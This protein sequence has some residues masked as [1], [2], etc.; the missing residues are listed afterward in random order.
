MALIENGGRGFL[1]GVLAGAGLVVDGRA[2]L[3]PLRPVGRPLT[4]ATLKTTLLA[5]EKARERIAEYGETMEDLLAEVRSEMTQ[6]SA[7]PAPAPSTPGAHG[8]A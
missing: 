2:L 4:K 6:D 3:G 8:G 5:I 7:T 1:L